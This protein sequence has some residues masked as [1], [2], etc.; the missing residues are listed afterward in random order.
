MLRVSSHSSVLDPVARSI[1][2]LF[3]AVKPNGEMQFLH[4]CG[5]FSGACLW[6]VE[7]MHGWLCLRAWPPRQS[8]DGYLS[9]VHRLM[10]KARA[11]G[12]FF[13]PAV[14]RVTEG[15]T[16]VFQS[17]RFWDMTLWMPGRADFHSKPQPHRLANACGSLAR[18]HLAWQAALASAAPC[19]AIGR[20][21][22]MRHEWMNLV[23]TGWRPTVLREPGVLFGNT[24][25]RAWSLLEVWARKL[26]SMLAP[27]NDRRVPVQPCHCDLWHDHVQFEQDEVVALLDYGSVK[28]DHVAVD[29]ARL[30][31][32]MAGD[33][34]DLWASGLAGYRTV[35]PLSIEEESLVHVLDRT[36]T[37][38]ALANWLKW[39]YHESRVFPGRQAVA[40]RLA[41]LVNR[42]ESWT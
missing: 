15:Q 27:W 34:Q 17:D 16:F 12:L 29:L 38:L 31:G 13:V 19:P 23:A 42:V 35:R 1:S 3:P 33:D 21:L 40:H 36:G 20:R 10:E 4:N 28:T 6:R 5:G 24:V 25:K 8:L 32:S 9:D 26:L 14:E 37:V 11:A 30:L 7:A 2:H 39:L 41:G 18:L 22:Q